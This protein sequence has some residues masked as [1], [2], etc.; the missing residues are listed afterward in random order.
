MAPIFDLNGKVSLITGGNRGIGLGFAT[1]LASA[2]ADIVIWGRDNVRNAEAV[3]LLK[4]H[5]TR[6]IAQRVNVADENEVVAAM[7]QAA[8]TMGRIDSVFAAAGISGQR[9][10]FESAL[11]STWHTTL[12]TNLLGVFWTFREACRVMVARANAGD[13][14]GSLVAVSSLSAVQGT[15]RLQ[16]YAASKGAVESI[17]RSLAVEFARYGIRANVVVPGWIATEINAGTRSSE[18]KE[19]VTGRIPARRWGSPDD[20]AGIAVYFASDTSSYH[21]GDTVRID[22][23]YAVF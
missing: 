19:V 9:E 8:Q 4:K 14:G 21:T 16:A 5:G 11:S 15:P 6:V 2:G 3:E 20:F 23:G 18:T 10:P 7:A 12:A 1:A 17:A 13:P 22:G